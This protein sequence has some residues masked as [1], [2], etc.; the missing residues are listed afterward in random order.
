MTA[1]DS[2]IQL[3]THPAK[4]S[5]GLS[6]YLRG[7]PAPLPVLLVA[8]QSPEDEVAL[9]D[10]RPE[11]VILLLHLQCL[12]LDRIREP[13]E[14]GGQLGSDEVTGRSWYGCTPNCTA[15]W[16]KVGGIAYCEDI[17]QNSTE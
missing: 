10:L 4:T 13:A 14:Y 9:Y 12:R 17:V 6:T 2:D 7:L 3:Y 5:L 16:R 8:G 1:P 15:E 11:H